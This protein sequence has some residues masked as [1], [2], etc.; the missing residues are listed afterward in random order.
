MTI[1]RLSEEVPAELWPRAVRDL[2]GGH[3]WGLNADSAYALVADA[4]HPTAA[5]QVQA[6]KGGSGF[7]T[8][9]LIGR[10]ANL[11]GIVANPT[12]DLRRLTAAF[13][14]GPLTVVVQPTASLAWAASRDAISIRMPADDSTR[15]IAFELGPLVAVAAA[16]NGQPAP[17]TAEAA[18]Q[19]W[20]SSVSDWLDSGPA[21]AALASTVVDFRGSLPNIIRL[22]AVSLAELQAVLP[23]VSRPAN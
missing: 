23:S 8:P 15:Q 13:W 2:R 22:G 4:F 20:G 17:L 3:I 10:S 18:E 21:D 14:P 1:H 5:T 7:I 16:R 19:L 11:E 12:D 6:L 9:I